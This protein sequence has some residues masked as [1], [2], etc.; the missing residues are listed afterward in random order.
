MYTLKGKIK[1]IKPTKV[2]SEKFSIRTFVV[3]TVAEHSQSIE[4]QTTQGKC[5]DLDTLNIGQDVTVSFKLR[6]REWKSPQGEVRHF[7][8]LEAWKIETIKF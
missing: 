3:Q 7:N 1:E 4:L 8:T 2:V 6:G 5:S